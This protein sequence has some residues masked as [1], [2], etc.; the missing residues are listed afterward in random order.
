MLYIDP[1]QAFGDFS[2][3]WQ[4]SDAEVAGDCTSYPGGEGINSD[5][6]PSPEPQDSE[7][8]EE[9][10]TSEEP[11][12]AKP[13]SEAGVNYTEEAEGAVPSMYEIQTNTAAGS[14]GQGECATVLKVTKVEV[15][16]A[17][18][19]DR[20]TDVN[21]LFDADLDTYYSVNR[22]STSITIEL[23]EETEVNGMAIGFFMKSSSEERIQ[24]FD[25]TVKKSDDDDW[26]T[27]LSRKESSGD[28]GIMQTFPFSSRLARY[29]RFESHGNS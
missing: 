21:N 20:T 24:T 2:S 29:V 14:S 25:V 9:E 13:A 10:T 6:S 17:D 23:E 26:R 27:V 15:E 28:M 1:C 22:E 12:E 16:H 8:A 19:A 3:Q 5:N 18:Y 11:E 7:Q 4:F